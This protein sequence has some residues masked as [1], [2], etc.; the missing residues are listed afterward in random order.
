MGIPGAV[1][2]KVKTAKHGKFKRHGSD[3]H[4]EMSMTLPEA[5]LGWSQTIRHIDGHTVDV[6]SDA[7]T[8][9]RQIIRVKGEG[10]PLRDD[11]ASFGDLIIKINVKFPTRLTQQQRDAIAEI[12]EQK[13]PRPE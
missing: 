3:L 9:D 10:M 13:P 11:P 12:F 8:K 5:L 2:L 1:I 6:S 7:I 4:M